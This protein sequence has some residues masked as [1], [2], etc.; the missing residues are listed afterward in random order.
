M[1]N[2]D[3]WDRAQRSIPGG[4]NSPVRSFRSVG[5]APFFVS[6]GSGPYLTD[7]EGRRY[8]KARLDR[9]ECTTLKNDGDQFGSFLF[10]VDDF[11]QIAAIVKPYKRPQLSDERRLELSRQMTEI[12]RQSLERSQRRSPESIS[13]SVDVV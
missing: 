4:V 11:E 5:S 2:A 8:I 10:H 7:V 9:L 13:A 12:R 3:L 1:S 6:S